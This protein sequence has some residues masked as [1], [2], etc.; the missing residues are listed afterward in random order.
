MEAGINEHTVT[1][2]ARRKLQG[3]RNQVPEPAFGH[4][5]LVGEKPIVGIETEPPG[6]EYSPA[7][8]ARIEEILNRSR[9]YRVHRFMPR[10][11]TSSKYF[12]YA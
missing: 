11:G 12:W 3:E 2:L 9:P 6:D 1:R 4:R 8:A 7:L 10:A 5:V